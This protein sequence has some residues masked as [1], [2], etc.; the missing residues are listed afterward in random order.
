MQSTNSNLNIAISSAYCYVPSLYQHVQ[1]IMN[2]K[3]CNCHF[4][5]HT[6]PVKLECL[7]TTKTLQVIWTNPPG[8]GISTPQEDWLC[9]MNNGMGS[10]NTT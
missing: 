9:L 8:G 3:A 2:T 4:Y 7:H 5:S 1:F 6:Y 10:H